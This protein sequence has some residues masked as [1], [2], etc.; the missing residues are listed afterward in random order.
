MGRIFNKDFAA[1]YDI[2][3]FEEGDGWEASAYKTELQP[4]Q[5]EKIDPTKLYPLKLK[6]GTLRRN[7][8]FNWQLTG[9]EL[10][11]LKYSKKNTGTC[12]VGGRDVKEVYYW[13]GTTRV[14]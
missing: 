8:M 14:F 2:K 9:N 3:T 12:K 6:R 10:K 11:K 13:T 4:I 7:E 1:D 5:P